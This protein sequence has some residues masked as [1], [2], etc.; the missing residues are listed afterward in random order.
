MI[1]DG[2]V[3]PEQV[4]RRDEFGNR[5]AARYRPSIPNFLKNLP[6]PNSDQHIAYDHNGLRV[7]KKNGRLYTI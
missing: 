6:A 7:I 4:H 2:I 3:Q 1:I 5:L